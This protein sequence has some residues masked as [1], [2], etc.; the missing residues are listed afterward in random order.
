MVKL[1]IMGKQKP[2]GGIPLGDFC[3]PNW[4]WENKNLLGVYQ[5]EVFVFPQSDIH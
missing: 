4:T 2:P 5:W 1:K 3:F